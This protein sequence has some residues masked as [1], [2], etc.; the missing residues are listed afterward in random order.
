MLNSFLGLATSSITSRM[1]QNSWISN[2]YQSDKH[3]LGIKVSLKECVLSSTKGSM[4]PTT[5]EARSTELN[6]PPTAINRSNPKTTWYPTTYIIRYRNIKAWPQTIF[7]TFRTWEIISKPLIKLLHHLSLKFFYYRYPFK[8]M[9]Q[10]ETRLYFEAVFVL[11]KACRTCWNLRRSISSINY[12]V[13]LL[14]LFQ[15]IVLVFI[16]N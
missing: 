6:A 10:G 7:F 14:S 1:G 5:C 4:Q 15:I 16:T 8:R 11:V 2:S 3:F 13:H 9:K 12:S